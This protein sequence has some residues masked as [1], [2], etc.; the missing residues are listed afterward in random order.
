MEGAVAEEEAN[1]GCGAL[2]Y[3]SQ[4]DPCP[5]ERDGDDG[6]QRH[7]IEVRIEASG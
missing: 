4:T 7:E 6:G 5:E 1:I 2:D 3:F